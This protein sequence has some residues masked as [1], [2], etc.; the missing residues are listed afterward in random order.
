MRNKINISLYIVVYHAL[1]FCVSELLELAAEVNT[2]HQ[3]FYSCME[4]SAKSANE[5]FLGEP[6]FPEYQG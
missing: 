5:M 2:C 3:Q 1:S 4:D 6:S